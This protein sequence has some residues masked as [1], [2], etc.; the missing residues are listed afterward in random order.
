M[1]T[2]EAILKK[3]MEIIEPF[4][5]S[6]MVIKPNSDLTGDLGMESIKVMDMLWVLED[7]LKMSIPL[8]ILMDVHTPDQLAH[9]ILTL[10]ERKNGT[11]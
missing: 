11:V 8:N 5:P 3:V 1:I 10:T 7:E 2:E 9:A 6:G 4:A